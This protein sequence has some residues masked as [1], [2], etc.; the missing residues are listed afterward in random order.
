MLAELGQ[1]SL[2]FAL[3][4]ALLQGFVPLVGVWLSRPLWAM[5]AMPLAK[6][7]FVFLALA[8]VLLAVLFVY[9]DFS[10]DYVAQNSNTALPLFYRIAAVWGGH[11]GSLLLWVFMLSGWSAAVT[12]FSRRML[13]EMRAL[14]VGVLGIISSG[15]LLFLLLTSSPFNRLS[16]VP[17]EGRDLN[18]LLQDPGLLI[19]PPIL[20]MGYVGFSVAFAFA[21]AALL[22]KRM[23]SAWARWARPWTVMAWCF[24]TLGITLGS[25]WAYY[26]LGWGGWWF[27]DP[28]ENASFM[29]WLVGTALLHSLAATEARGVFKPWT[30]LLAILTFSLCLLGTFLVRSGVLISVHSFAADPE[31]GLFIL[32]LLAVLVGGALALYAWRAPTLKGGGSFTPLSRET[33]ILLNNIFFTVAAFSVL[34]GTL[35]PL[36]LDALGFGKISVGPPYFN[37]VF[38]PLAVVPAALAVVG[39]IS[40]WKSDSLARIKNK[41]SLPLVAAVVCGVLSP[42]LAEGDYQWTA[43]IGLFLAYWV[44]FGS[45]CVAFEYIMAEKKYAAGFGMLIAH[46]GVAVFVAGVTLVSVY[47]AEKDLRLAVNERQHFDGYVWT[48]ENIGD[49][50][51]ENYEAVVGVVRVERHGKTIAHLK[52]EKRIYP[53]RPDTPM[54]EAGIYPVWHGDLY[55]SLGEKL[56]DGSWSARLQVKPFIRFVWGGALLMALGGGCCR[57]NPANNASNIGKKINSGRKRFMFCIFANGL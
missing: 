29:P 6:A 48:L 27:W 4:L 24:L 20:Y 51:G 37:A 36:L 16:P 35:Y 8:I 44:F 33:G 28:V 13:M 43:A 12:I 1:L 30:A 52:P 53:S 14:V 18:P 39:A 17:A 19:H 5:A 50:E 34:L 38:V 55:I 22:S 2:A 11:E 32:T 46:G 57:Y 40:H 9:H 45:L 56:P 49:Q 15:F 21:V 47:S 10:V 31:R 42:L 41:L 54:T 3:C 26:E 7:Q 23:D 25:W